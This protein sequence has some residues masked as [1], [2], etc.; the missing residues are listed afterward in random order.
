MARLQ[1]QK[2]VRV[3]D[4]EWRQAIDD[5]GRFLDQ[6]GKLA[7]E[8]GWTAGELFDVPRIDGTC[9]LVW[10]IKGAPMHSLGP[11]HAVLRGGERVFDKLSRGEWVSSYK[12]G[13][14]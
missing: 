11:E 14:V 9:G 7:M 10:F 4:A 13:R 6:W 1:V 3:S 2:P 5:A 8:L 12:K